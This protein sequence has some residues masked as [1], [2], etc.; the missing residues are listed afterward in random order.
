MWS[1]LQRSSKEP[2]GAKEWICNLFPPIAA[3]TYYIQHPNYIPYNIH[4][5]QDQQKLSKYLK[6]SMYTLKKYTIQDK[7]RTAM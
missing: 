5:V 6:N 1:I 7:Q 3:A 4:I 2:M